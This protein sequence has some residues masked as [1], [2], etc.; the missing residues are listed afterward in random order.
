MTKLRLAD[1]VK[2]I[3][4]QMLLFEAKS[5]QYLASR[6][7]KVLASLQRLNY[8]FTLKPFKVQ[9]RAKYHLRLKLHI[10]G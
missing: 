9:Q 6:K 3:T 5:S 7:P 2:Q 10:E 8:N 1:P 4:G